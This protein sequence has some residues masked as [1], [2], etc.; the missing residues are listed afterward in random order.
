ME[1]KPKW[2]RS[3]IHQESEEV[4]PELVLKTERTIEEL[5]ELADWPDL[6][7]KIW[8]HYWESRNGWKLSGRDW[9][10]KQIVAAVRNAKK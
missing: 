6:T 5:K 3:D 1:R 9:P 2:L 10:Y 4:S 7:T 8:R